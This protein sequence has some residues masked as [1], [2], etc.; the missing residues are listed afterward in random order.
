[1]L[2]SSES[3]SCLVLLCFFKPGFLSL[4]PM[5]SYWRSPLS[6]PRGSSV[7]V[8]VLYRRVP[9]PAWCLLKRMVVAGFV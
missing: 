1:M 3:Q 5:E 9:V 7:G 8:C 4:C 6:G 2:L